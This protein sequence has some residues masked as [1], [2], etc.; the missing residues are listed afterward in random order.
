MWVVGEIVDVWGGIGWGWGRWVVF[1]RGEIFD[2]VKIG[3]WFD[4]FDYLF[5]FKYLNVFMSEYVLE[6]FFYCWEINVR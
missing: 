3:W 1:L 4:L 6:E 2:V 5:Y